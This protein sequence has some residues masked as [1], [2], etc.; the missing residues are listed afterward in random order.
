ML[1]TNSN[2]GDCG[3]PT[4]RFTSPRCTHN[5][6]SECCK[7][8]HQYEHFRPWGTKEAP[9]TIW[10]PCSVCK[11]KKA[12]T[13]EGG[14]PPVALIPMFGAQKQPP[15]PL[16]AT[17]DKRV[18]AASHSLTCV[19]DTCVA[20]AREKNAEKTGF[21]PYEAPKPEPK[22][23]N[24]VEHDKLDWPLTR[25]TTVTQYGTWEGYCG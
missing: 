9:H 20:L 7:K 15:L 4:C 1:E 2:W 19:C 25:G 12:A 5:F 21:V 13:Q 8:D 23:G 17:N 6:C 24:M 14:A 3:R 11:A 22:L 16:V 10:C 18:A